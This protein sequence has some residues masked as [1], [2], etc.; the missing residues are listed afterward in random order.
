MILVRFIAPRHNGAFRHRH[1]H[2]ADK[3]GH[4]A[5]AHIEGGKDR[6][7]NTV[8]A[9]DQTGG[10]ALE[11][12]DQSRSCLTQAVALQSASDQHDNNKN[13]HAAV[14]HKGAAKGL[15]QGDRT[16][17]AHDRSH[18]GCSQNDENGVQLQ[19]KA[20]DDDDNAK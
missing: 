15:Q 7:H 10:R 18:N 1:D 19:R 20:D 13:C 3:A 14:G 17:T 4:A 6:T 5:K 2:R 8:N 11:L 12:A 16:Q 9:N